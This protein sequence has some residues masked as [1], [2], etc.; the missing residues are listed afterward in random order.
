GFGLD[1]QFIEVADYEEALQKARDE[2]GIGVVSR[3][4]GLLFGP[5]Y[6]LRP[7]P[8]VFS[9]VPLRFAS[10]KGKNQ[11]ILQTLDRW[12]SRFKEDPQ[13]VYHQAIHEFL[14]IQTPWKMPRW[15]FIILI[16]IMGTVGALLG[17]TSFLRHQVVRKTREVVEKNIALQE[18]ITRRQEAEAKLSSRLTLEQM[19]TQVSTQVF[20][21][22]SPGVAAYLAL[23]KIGSFLQAEYLLAKLPQESYSFKSPQISGDPESLL[24]KLLERVPF[25]E[26]WEKEGEIVL[27]DQGDILPELKKSVFF[28]LSLR[29]SEGEGVLEGTLKASENQEERIHHLT[30]VMQYLRTLFEYIWAIKQR[31]EKDRWFM[32]TLKSLGDAII[33]TD[34]EGRVTF[35][36]PIAEK[37]TGWTHGEAQGR[38]VEEVLVLVN[39]N[40]GKPVESPARQILQS[41]KG[42]DL[43]HHALLTRRD[44]G[45]IIVDDS[46]APILDE[47][48]TIRGAVLVFRDITERRQLEVQVQERE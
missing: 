43:A 36:N 29:F 11:E 9:P 21:S 2:K 28:A 32:V 15:V 1:C 42:V 17:F 38:P 39:E 20:S 18:E 23:E 31:Q 22:R 37:L 8:L 46:G 41:R 16:L 40:T 3:T 13:S 34:A 12:I 33:T 24:P 44:G 25:R 19:L 27:F 5:R 26:K 30:L 6:D 4:F 7:S 47:E 14:E 35:L 45:K 48:G 10:P